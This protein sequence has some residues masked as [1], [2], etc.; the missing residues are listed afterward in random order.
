MISE[1]FYVEHGKGFIEIH[2]QKPVF[3]LGQH[4]YKQTLETALVNVIIV[5]LN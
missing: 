3:L 4:D 2:H 5:C 1:D